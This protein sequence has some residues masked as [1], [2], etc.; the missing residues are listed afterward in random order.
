[1]SYSRALSRQHYDVVI[2]GS[3][4]VGAT[5]AN[6]LGHTLPAL[7]V[8]LIDGAPPVTHEAEKFDARVVALSKASEAILRK[9]QVWNRVVGRRACAYV[10]MHVWDGEGCGDIHFDSRSLQQDNLGHIVENSLLVECLEENLTRLASVECAY[11]VTVDACARVGERATLHLSNAQQIEAT[12]VVAADGAQSFLRTLLGFKVREWDYGQNAIVTTIRT[13]LP[14]QFTA[15]QRFTREGPVAF[16]PLSTDGKEQHYCS[17]VWSLEESKVAA[18]MA[19]GDEEFCA[20]LTRQFEARLG[21]V[22]STDTRYTFPLRQRHATRYIAEHVALV[23]D[24]AHTIHPLAGQG[25]NLG[26]YDVAALAEEIQRAWQRGLSLADP[27]VLKRYERRRQTHNLLAM[28]AMEGFK[29]VFG[30]DDIVL[31]WARNEGLR[32]VNHVPWL[33]NTLA[34]IASARP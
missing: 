12:L 28:S 4:I 27:S 15:W 33:K 19:L 20:A 23:G 16:L 7:S 26:I 30:S 10:E 1:M 22:L 13:Q 17:L 25:A 3:G 24:A 18:V 21:Q 29:R 6:V 31:R 8:A 2:V 11:S 5:L 14:H 34:K 32:A 9:I